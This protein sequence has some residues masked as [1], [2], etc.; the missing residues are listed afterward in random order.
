ME[1][2]KAAHGPSARG[3][4]KKPRH[5]SPQFRRHCRRHYLW[6]KHQPCLDHGDGGGVSNGHGV[7]QAEAATSGAAAAALEGKAALVVRLRQEAEAA[8]KLH[9]TRT[10]LIATKDAQIKT[11]QVVAVWC[12]GVFKEAI[13]CPSPSATAGLRYQIMLSSRVLFRSIMGGPA[14]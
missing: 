8:E 2:P 13:P 7:S 4:L 1:Q 5:A 9:A 6:T 11:L 14:G 10:A 3:A 12:W